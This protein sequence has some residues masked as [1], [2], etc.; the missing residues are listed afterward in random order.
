M[1]RDLLVPVTRTAGDANALDTALALAGDAGARLTVADAFA[2]PGPA[3]GPWGLTVETALGQVYADVR[4]DAAR[5]AEGLRE[6]LRRQ[7]VPFEVRLVESLFLEPQYALVP[8]ARCADIAVLTGADEP[9]EAAVIR[10]YFGALLLDSGRPVLVVPPRAAPQ[11]GWRHAVVAW[12]PAREAARAA[13]DALPL[14]RRAETVDLLEI[15]DDQAAALEPEAEVHADA[16]LAA[17]LGR[18]G[19][20]VR[21]VVRPRGGETVGAAILGHCRES[22]AD[23]LVSGG[24]GHSR[25][26]EWAWGGVTRDLLEFAHLPVL[27]SH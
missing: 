10:G 3:P 5:R 9:G 6:R 19:L 24:Y 18:H 17:H 13:H 16:D 8:L 25:L 4:A 20:R 23:L 7:A 27:F 26:R 21:S 14:L 15:R 22:D 1:I 12:R 11:S 2:L